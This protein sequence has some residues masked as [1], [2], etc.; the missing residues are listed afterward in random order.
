LFVLLVAA[1]APLLNAQSVRI[2]RFSEGKPFQMGKVTSYRIVHPDLGARRLTLNYSTSE[3]GFEFSQHV[4]DGSDDTIVVL[5]G[6]GDLRQGGT[7]TP[8]PAGVCAFVPAG[9]V[10]GTITT[11]AGTTMISFQTPPDMVLYTGAR[12]SAKTGVAPQGQIT[13]GAVKYIPF[14]NAQGFFVHPGTGSQRVA[15]ARRVLRRG[16]TIETGIAVRGEQLLF[17]WKGAA[18][19]SHG[20]SDYDLREKDTAFITGPATVMLR[21]ASDTPAI[22][23]EVQAPPFRGW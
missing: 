19:V 1:L 16:A 7:R 20:R 15:V 23:F 14:G 2:I 22:V 4:H 11:A 6:A 21:G 5:E 12:D 8:I 9:Q 13:P 17:V 3:P 18:S 10:H